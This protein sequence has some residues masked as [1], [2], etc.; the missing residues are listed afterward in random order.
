MIVVAISISLVLLQLCPCKL[1]HPNMVPK[2]MKT[3]TMQA[4]AAMKEMK[5]VKAM[6]AMKAMKATT[7]KS[8]AM[9]EITSAYG[10]AAE[11]TA[12]GKTKK[13]RAQLRALDSMKSDGSDD[14]YFDFNPSYEDEEDDRYYEEDKLFAEFWDSEAGPC[15]HLV[16][17]RWELYDN[18]AKWKRQRA[19]REDAMAFAANKIHR[20]R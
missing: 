5:A 1:Y 19:V 12:I 8:G 7:M 14:S 2:P 13:K 11:P 4:A 20:R 16:A 10:F 15:R 18:F 9:T 6:K 17:D 3:K